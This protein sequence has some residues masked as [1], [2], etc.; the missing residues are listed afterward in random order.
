M[1]AIGVQTRWHRCGDAHRSQE[2]VASGWELDCSNAFGGHKWPSEGV[3]L[4]GLRVGRTL[5]FWFQH[6]GGVPSLLTFPSVPNH[7]T[8]GIRMRLHFWGTPFSLPVGSASPYSQAFPSAS[9]DLAESGLSPPTEPEADSENCAL[10]G[11]ELWGLSNPRGWVVVTPPL[12]LPPGCPLRCDCPPDN[13][14]PPPT[15]QSILISS[16]SDG[17]PRLPHM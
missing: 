5:K 13:L 17:A 15:V 14:L 4:H 16:D 9:P 10:R 2:V 11:S 3:S 6:R 7:E 12:P 1:S 8:D